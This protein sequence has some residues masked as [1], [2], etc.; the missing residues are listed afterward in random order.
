MPI[1]LLSIQPHKISR[2]LSGYITYIY[3]APKVG[4]TTLGAQ[5]PSPILFAFERGYNAIAGVMAQDITSWS[6]L[7]QAVRQL[8]QPEVK[9][10]FKSVIIDTV[11]IAA[12]LCDKYVC[13]QN[14]VDSINKIPYGQG[15][16]L[17]KKEFEEV[18]RTITQLGYAVCFISHVKEVPFKRQDGTEYTLIRPSISDTYN[19]IVENMADLYGYMHTVYIDGHS[20]VRLTLRSVDGTVSAGGRFKYIVPEI[21]SSY[22]D[23]VKALNDAI[24]KEAEIKGSEFVTEERT[25][26]VIKTELD[27]D[28]LI[29]EFNDLVN[30]LISSCAKEDFESNWSPRITQI[31]ETYLGKGKKVNQC[32]RDQVEML[33]LIVADLNE[34]IK[35]K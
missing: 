8:K 1:D 28:S 24:D 35:N 27:Y 25:P 34:L 15:W 19:K 26:A 30:S 21:G 13:S 7:K 6:E 11:D 20:E 14:E 23:L 17:L 4:K 18:F 10:R 31:I 16:N 29:K 12:T 9:E 2:D 32:T 3:G 33:S 5:M 22:N